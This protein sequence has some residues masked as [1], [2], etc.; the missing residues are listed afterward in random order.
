M[1][2]SGERSMELA[3]VDRVIEYS[4]G[5]AAE[6]LARRNRIRNFV[7]EH[8]L[9]SGTANEMILRSFLA[10]HSK[11]KFAVGQGFVYDPSVS[12]HDTGCFVSKQCDIIVYDRDYPL[13]HSEGEVKI[14]LPQAVKLF[15]EV[16]TNLTTPEL[17][18]TTEKSGALDNVRS[19]KQISGMSLTP[20]LIFA[21]ESSKVKTLVKSLREYPQQLPVEHQPTAILLL[22]RGSIIHRWDQQGK[23]TETYQVIEGSNDKSAAVMAFLLLLYFERITDG[24]WGGSQFV[25]MLTRMLEHRTK[26][27]KDVEDFRLSES[28]D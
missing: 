19:A 9:T 22:D 16:K 14:I 27:V 23:E 5:I 2:E 20:G 24:L 10:E 11:G 18:G 4:A 6:F 25:N 12:N 17:V 26:R 7:T 15:I 3:N 8:N 28:V 1:S 13:V 21:F